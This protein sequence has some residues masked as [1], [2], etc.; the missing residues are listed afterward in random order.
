[1]NAETKR[2]LGKGVTK[3]CERE[4]GGFISRVF[5]R[6]IED[7]SF[8]TMLNPQHL[9]HHVNYRYFKMESLNDAFRIL[10][11]GVWM[12][13]ANLQF[14]TVPIHNWHKKIKY[15]SA[16]GH[17]NPMQI[18]T[19]ILKVKFDHLRQRSYLQSYLLMNLT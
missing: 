1:M 14:F 10:R 11:K 7:G 15:E 4:K 16:T 19:K 5:N 12:T 13:S 6:Q 2:L 3:E 9:N 18:F 17:F 8:R